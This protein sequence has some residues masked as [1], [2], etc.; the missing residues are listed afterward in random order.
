[1]DNSA[2]TTMLPEINQFSINTSVPFVPSSSY[3]LDQT[4]PTTKTVDFG[5]IAPNSVLAAYTMCSESFHEVVYHRETIIATSN[6]TAYKIPKHDFF[7]HMARETRR[8]LQRVISDYVSPM[9]RLTGCCNF[10]PSP[11]AIKAWRYGRTK[12]HGI[13]CLAQHARHSFFPGTWESQGEASQ[14]PPRKTNA[15]PRNVEVRRRSATTPW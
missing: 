9:M 13:P 2:S 12:H 5:R 7:M 8:T 14:A 10:R 4:G 11:P 6:I 1:M 3:K 15:P